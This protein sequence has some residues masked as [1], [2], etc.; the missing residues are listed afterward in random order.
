MARDFISP[1]KNGAELRRVARNGNRGPFPLDISSPLTLSLHCWGKRIPWPLCRCR[2]GSPRRARRSPIAT[3]RD[4]ASGAARLVGLARRGAEVLP[5][6]SLASVSG[7][8]LLPS[9]ASLPQG[10]RVEAE[11]SGSHH[12]VCRYVH[13]HISQ[14]ESLSR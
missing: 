3:P 7:V 6:A 4:L 8:A 14:L 10:L 11:L 2:R 9:S 12:L 13:L 1:G 5:P